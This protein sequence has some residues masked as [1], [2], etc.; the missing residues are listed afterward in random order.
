M[1]T[2]D[3]LIAI[4]QRLSNMAWRAGRCRTLGDDDREVLRELADRWDRALRELRGEEK[5]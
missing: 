4:G 3:E 2:T 5:P 1:T